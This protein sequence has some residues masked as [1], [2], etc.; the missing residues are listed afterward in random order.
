MKFE[1]MF[2]MVMAI[3]VL[4]LP[5]LLLGEHVAKKKPQSKFT[6]WWR[7]HIMADYND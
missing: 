6:T 5:M 1:T 2:I 7:K 3:A 4:P